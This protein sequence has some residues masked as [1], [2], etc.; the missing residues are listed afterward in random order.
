MS[1]IDFDEL[2]RAV[3]SLM[4]SRQPSGPAEQSSV[5]LAAVAPP[6]SQPA[7]ETSTPAPAQ[8]DPVATQPVVAANQPQPKLS[9]KRRG[10]FMDVMH[11]SSDMKQSDPAPKLA[12]R[13]QVAATLQPTG[14]E[15]ASES[16]VPEPEVQPQLDAPS[17][18]TAMS[19]PSIKATAPVDQAAPIPAPENKVGGDSEPMST[20]FLTDAKVDKRPLGGLQTDEPKLET[21]APQPAPAA[22][23]ATDPSVLPAEL[24]QDIL[25]V[26]ADP[27]Q[28]AASG[29][30]VATSTT[31]DQAAAQPQSIS[32]MPTTESIGSL[33]Q[34]PLPISSDD[35]PSESESSIF[36]TDQYQPP[37]KHPAKRKS[38]PV[39]LAIVMLVILGTGGGIAFYLLSN[40]Y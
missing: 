40:G 27:A 23:E 35:G 39:V 25:A 16:T 4:Q 32:V 12:P 18:P 37:L 9:V 20:P 24:Q 8:A 26:E 11:S 34:N 36:D 1:D 19:D 31:S 33:P 38:W 15:T 6:A 30:G 21:S 14:K 29:S 28:P 17:G 13:K 7:V 5:E 22:A 3:N 10:Q 2:D